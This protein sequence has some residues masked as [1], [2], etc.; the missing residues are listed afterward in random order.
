MSTTDKIIKILQSFLDHREPVTITELSRLSGIN[1]SIIY[2]VIAPLCKE[3]YINK[4]PKSNKYTVGPKFLEFA[5]LAR[6]TLNIENVAQPY[7][8]KLR[9]LTN[10]NIQFSVLDGKIAIS[11]L[12]LPSTQR[13][14]VVLEKNA[15]LPLYCTGA[16]KIFLAHMK[17]FELD[18]YLTEQKALNKYTVNTITN[19]TQLKKHLSDIS[20]EGVAIDK[21]EYIE[22]I[23]EIAV[24]LKNSMGRVI[25][26][27]GILMPSA[28]ATGDRLAELAALLKRTSLEISTVVG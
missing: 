28:R 5:N 11:T 10:E 25:A 15:E 16:G 20:K 1:P 23:T 13:L 24:P 7:L 14:R 6:N 4:Q 22:G 17:G 8:T 12:V 9:N 21:E 26:S 27:I 18:R 2:R 3:G 19:Q